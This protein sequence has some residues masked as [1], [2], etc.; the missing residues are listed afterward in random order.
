MSALDAAKRENA[1]LRQRIA[2]LSAA[3]LR[4]GA[5]LDLDTV[6]RA[7]VDGARALAGARHGRV[8]TIDEAGA[9]E[10]FIAPGLTPHERRHMAAWPHGQAF[11]EHLRDLPGALRLADVAQH[12]RSLG[13][14]ESFTLSRTLLATPMRHRGV[15][16]GSFFLGEK[17]GG[18]AFTEEDAEV[19]ALFASQAAA[20]ANA[21]THR[22]ERR[23]R[24]D[25]EAQVDTSPV[26]VVVFDA[27]AG[28]PVRFN[29]EA[30]RIVEG[31]G[32]PGQAPEE[33]AQSIAC[34]RPTGARCASARSAT[35][36]SCAPRRSRSRCR[37]G[38][39]SRR[40]S[41]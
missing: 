16:V 8:A 25:L 38:A 1:A 37:T 32:T 11:F 40:S 41:T 4:I 28:W 10:A 22:D 30:R 36:R 19:L 23:A 39:T 18:E 15:H 27:A 34:R 7:A 2:T 35:P 26:G 14:A 6:L 17:V 33:L 13:Y 20:I 29:R 9:I 3:I 21:R 31:L 12:L 5:S 24:A